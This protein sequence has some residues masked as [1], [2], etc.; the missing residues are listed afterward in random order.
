MRKVK[1]IGKTISNRKVVGAGSS[2]TRRE[3]VKTVVLST[4]WFW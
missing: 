1:K 4:V 2:S 3:N